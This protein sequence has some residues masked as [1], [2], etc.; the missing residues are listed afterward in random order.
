[1]KRMIGFCLLLSALVLPQALSSPEASV[2]KPAK[3]KI[4]NNHVHQATG[5][6]MFAGNINVRSAQNGNIVLILDS[7]M[8]EAPD[9]RPDLVIR[10]APK[11][12][13]ARYKNLSFDLEGARLFAGDRRVAVIGQD[14]H[15]WISLSLEPVKSDDPSSA[16][17][18][19]KGTDLPQTIRISQ[20]HALHRQTIHPLEDGTLPGIDLEYRIFIDRN[21]EIKAQDDEFEIENPCLGGGAGAT[22]CSYSCG[23]R[24]CNV[25]CGSGFACCTCRSNW[26]YCFCV[27]S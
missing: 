5:D 24:T 16:L 1:M 25:S 3:N 2:G 23:G 18:A 17:Y 6:A 21:K 26:P 7:G 27:Q 10:F 14:G 19:N 8:A 20:G 13:K 9:G 4:T 15:T 11:K 12:K 22:S